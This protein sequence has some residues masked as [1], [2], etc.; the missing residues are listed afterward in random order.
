[1]ERVTLARPAVGVP[2]PRQQIIADENQRR[3]HTQGGDRQLPV[4]TEHN[5]GR[6]QNRQ[7]IKEQIRKTVNEEVHDFIGIVV[8]PAA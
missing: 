5:E 4:H 2:D 6:H 3:Q 8:H 7:D 1:M